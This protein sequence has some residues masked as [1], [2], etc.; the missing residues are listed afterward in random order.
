MTRAIPIA[1]ARADRLDRFTV[2][3]IVR[4]VFKVTGLFDVFGGAER[5]KKGRKENTAL[6]GAKQ[7][8]GGF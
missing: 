2:I 5:E 3:W 1:R 6:S 8:G 7:D 4:A